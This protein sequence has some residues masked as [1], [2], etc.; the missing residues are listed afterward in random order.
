MSAVSL[1]QNPRTRPLASAERDA[2]ILRLRGLGVGVEA[3]AAQLQISERTCRRVI[4]RRIQ[5]LNAEIRCSAEAIRSQH[6]LE[7]AT[8]RRQL[9]PLLTAAAPSDRIAA[10]RTWLGVLTRESALLGLDAPGVIEVHAIDA[11][12]EGLLRHL[13]QRLPEETM[14]QVLH[15]LA[16]TIPASVGGA[17]E[18]S[19]QL[20]AAGALRPGG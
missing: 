9:A 8:L 6:M 11:A 12:A 5:A 3:I 20:A 1:H 4:Q 17:A 18:G 15:A 13:G 2:H 14:Q 10:I 7:L 19:H 16:E